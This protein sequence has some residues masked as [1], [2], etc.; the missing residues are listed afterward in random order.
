MGGDIP[1]YYGDDFLF[2]Y[3]RNMAYESK[4]LICPHCLEKRQLIKESE[5]DSFHYDPYHDPF[6]FDTREV[7]ISSEH[8]F[9]IHIQNCRSQITSDGIKRATTDKLR[10]IARKMNAISKME[11]G[12]KRIRIT[13]STFIFFVDQDPISYITFDPEFLS[14]GGSYILTDVYT[15]PKYRNRGY[16]SKLFEY[17]IKELKLDVNSLW[18]SFPV[19]DLGKPLILKYAKEEVMA[20]ASSYS[21]TWTINDLKEHW[22]EIM[23]RY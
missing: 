23:K 7:E 14:G 2:F 20:I 16:A 1:L 18:I 15:I 17:A 12:Y 4:I 3:G 10:N 13:P 6:T 19:S 21:G 22:I 11:T 5:I 9:L 8:D